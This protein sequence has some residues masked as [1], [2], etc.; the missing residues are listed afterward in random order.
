MPGIPQR[1]TKA[2]LYLGVDTF[3]PLGAPGASV[4]EVYTLTEMVQ[5]STD[6]TIVD[7][8]SI[9]VQVAHGGQNVGG[10]PNATTFSI[11]ILA[12]GTYS[13]GNWGV[14]AIQGYPGLPNT[15][16]SFSG[17]TVTITWHVYSTEDLIAAGFPVRSDYEVKVLHM[18]LVLD[19]VLPET[20]G[21][22]GNPPPPPPPPSQVERA[23]TGLSV[24]WHRN[25]HPEDVVLCRL[26]RKAHV[27]DPW[28]GWSARPVLMDE[29]HRTVEALPKGGVRYR[30]VWRLFTYPGTTVSGAELFAT[31]GN[32]VVGETL[33]A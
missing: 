17:K 15:D 1:I 21:G 33:V 5:G 25:Q 24:N 14:Y 16:I 4:T 29:L 22:G 19:V 18:T 9:A 20:G 13:G 3:R 12:A 26:G 30:D 27:T 23:L 32:A 2:G 7:I 6:Y 10:N 28:A 11:V 31:V 8:S